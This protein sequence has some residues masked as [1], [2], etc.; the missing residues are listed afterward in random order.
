LREAIGNLKTKTSVSK[1]YSIS[2]VRQ[3]LRTGVL[4]VAA[5]AEGQR[6]FNAF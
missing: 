2:V 5:S 4:L 3:E 6:H 1:V